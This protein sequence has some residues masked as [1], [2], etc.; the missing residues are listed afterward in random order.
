MISEVSI[1]RNGLL[2]VSRDSVPKLQKAERKEYRNGYV[3]SYEAMSDGFVTTG[4]YDSEGKWQFAEPSLINE[5]FNLQGVDLLSE[6]VV[7]VDGRKMCVRNT[8]FSKLVV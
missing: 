6:N 1:N 2:V 4:I 7:I 8:T 5:E 3:I